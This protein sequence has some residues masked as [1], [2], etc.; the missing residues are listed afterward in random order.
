MREQLET[1]TRLQALQIEAID[2]QCILDRVPERLQAVDAQREEHEAGLAEINEQ[3]ASLNRSY[4]TLERDAKANQV[5]VDKSQ[6]KLRSV[7]TN[8]EYQSSLKEIDDLKRKNSQLEDEMLDCLDRIEALE[9]ALAE[10]KAEFERLARELESEKADILKEAEAK[11][12]ELDRVVS[13]EKEVAQTVPPDLLTVFNTVKQ[14]QARGIAIAPV[15]DALCHACHVKL[16]PQRYNELQRGDQLMF[17]PNCQRIIY[18]K[19]N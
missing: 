7:K 11:E 8:K 3:L 10:R 1:L 9:H 12:R 6:D 16:P 13:A 17:C 14:K 5:L 18:W 19:Q 15:T 4:R 2:I